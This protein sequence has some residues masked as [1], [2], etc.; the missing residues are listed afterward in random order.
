MTSWSTIGFLAAALGCGLIDSSSSA[1]LA[2]AWG[3]TAMRIEAMSP[4]VNEHA[5]AIGRFEA[6]AL[7]LGAVFAGRTIMCAAAF[8]LGRAL[9]ALVICLLASVVPA[10]RAARLDP[11][12]TI[13]RSQA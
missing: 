11:I 6:W 12:E 2:A 3:L 10:R 13:R 5:A 8:L 7:F 1:I 4:V 9:A